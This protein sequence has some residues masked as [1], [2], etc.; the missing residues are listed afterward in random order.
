VPENIFGPEP[1]HEWCYYYQKADL[2]RSLQDWP[3][4]TALADEAA[5]S[6]FAPQ[7]GVELLPFIQA[8]A[9]QGQWEPALEAS[10]R[11]TQLTEN[12]NRPVCK[13]WNRLATEAPAEGRQ[14][15]VDAARAEF[16]CPV[17]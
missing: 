16:K 10:R 3:R 8:Y 7:N 14:P 9:M 4:V 12:M 11:V 1:A 6:G 13:M 5:A 15:A 17:R 2:A